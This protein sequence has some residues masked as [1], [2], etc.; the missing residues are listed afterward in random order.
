MDRLAASDAE[1]ILYERFKKPVKDPTKYVVGFQTEA[2]RLLALDPTLRPPK[3][4]ASVPSEQNLAKRY[5]C[6]KG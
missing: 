3:E 6:F 4:E 5:R 1:D 2:G